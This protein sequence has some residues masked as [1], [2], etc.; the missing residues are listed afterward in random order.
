MALF[1]SKEERRIERS[2]AVRKTLGL[3]ANQIKKLKQQ[4]DGYIAS[5]KASLRSGASAQLVLAKKALKATMLQRRRLDHQMLTLK[6]AAQ[7][8]DQAEMHGKFASA[9]SAVFKTIGELFSSVDMTATQREFEVAM[10]KAQSMEERVDLFLETSNE[11][12]F[13]EVGETGELVTDQEIDK[14]IDVES[15]G[16]EAAVDSE[17]DSRLKA[18]QDELA[19]G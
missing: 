17:I 12:V 1:K 14:L 6:I 4:E 16:G 8:K 13:G 18:I 2:L 9:L 7:M 11:C 5:A 19:K 10:A 15:A 3:F